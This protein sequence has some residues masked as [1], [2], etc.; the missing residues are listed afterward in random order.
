MY[1]A[2]VAIQLCDHGGE[3]DASGH[4]VVTLSLPK[5]T[6]DKQPVFKGFSQAQAAEFNAQML[7]ESHPAV[8]QVVQ[9]YGM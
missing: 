3:G 5:P 1:R 7:I 8:F 6:W 4:L 2:I 9:M